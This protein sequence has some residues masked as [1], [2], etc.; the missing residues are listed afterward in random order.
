LVAFNWPTSGHQ[1]TQRLW[2]IFDG[3][4]TVLFLALSSSHHTAAPPHALVS[5]KMEEVWGDI[6]SLDEVW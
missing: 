5:L 1:Y 6:S 2:K 4:G 3:G